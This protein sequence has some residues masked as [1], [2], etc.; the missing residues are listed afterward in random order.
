[1]VM[2]LTLSD[3]ILRDLKMDERAARVEIACR[4]FEAG[5]LQLWPA[6][7]LAGLSRV[8]MEDALAERGIPIYRV[9]QQYWEQERRSLTGTLDGDGAAGAT[10]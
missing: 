4:L 5:K 10:P 8:Q 3:D 9:T 2:A 6:A 7:K 1:M